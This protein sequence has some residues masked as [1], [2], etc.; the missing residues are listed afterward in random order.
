MR[1]GFTIELNLPDGL[2]DEEFQR[3]VEEIKTA[4]LE[5]ARDFDLDGASIE[6]V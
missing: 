6:V 4:L 5:T 3:R 2:P 1:T